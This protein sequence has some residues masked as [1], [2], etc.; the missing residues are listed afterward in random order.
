VGQA[1][2]NR[3]TAPA[4]PYRAPQTPGEP[5]RPIWRSRGAFIVVAALLVAIPIAVYARERWL[6][7]VMF[8]LSDAPF[9][10][11]WVACAALLGDLVLR[12]RDTGTPVHP[13]LRFATRVGLGLGIVSLCALGL[14]LAGILNR[15]TSALLLLIGPLAALPRF[16]A[17]AKTRPRI[18]IERW[19]GEPL[20]GS[21]LL[22][23]AAPVVGVMITGASIVPGLL[24]K[25]DDPHPYDV[26]EYHLQIPREWYELGRIVPLRHNVFSYFPNGVEVQYLM[27]MHLRGGA[28]AAMFQCQCFSLAWV[29]LA[30]ATV[31]GAIR[32]LGGSST[33]ASA[34][35]VVTIATPWMVM[36]G[37]VAYTESALAMYTALAAAWLLRAMVTGGRGRTA[38]MIVAGVMAGL[39]CGVKYT[40]VPMV[41]VA[42]GVIALV[43]AVAGRDRRA[44]LAPLLSFALA[45][46]AVASP[47]LIRNFVWTGNPVFPLAMSTLGRGHFD[48]VQVE[49]FRIAHSPTPRQRPLTARVAR[50]GDVILADWQYGYL[51]W[52]IA[53]VA[54]AL[55]WR[56]RE[57][58]AIAGYLVIVLVI[59]IGFTHLLG[60]FYVLTIPVAATSIG[61]VAWRHWPRLLA[62]VTPLFVLVS[63]TLTNAPLERGA[64]FARMGVEDFTYMI[65]QALAE[66]IK[67]T[68]DVWLVGDVQAFLYPVAASRLHYRTVFDLPGDA[69]DMYQAWLG[70][71]RDKAKGLIVVDPVEVERLSKTYY[72]VPGL[73]PDFDGPLDGPSIK[74]N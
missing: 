8:L 67:T 59:W 14:G 62:V 11:A 55:A 12:R 26:L 38:A 34:G 60:R 1:N 58:R 73:P 13:A 31:Y 25:P 41:A 3:S 52:P 71:P 28:W 21:W 47:W 36:L 18:P 70:I 69:T 22:V 65:P 4:I 7:V 35:A 46:A 66:Q 74:A 51:L 40:A 29:L 48:P 54:L 15:R 16:V 19:L 10:A 39:A 56:R 5:S 45:A 23:C 61:L 30:G 68:S 64:R 6:A 32:G 33:T 27:A 37:S 49:R 17:W 42:V 50:A 63:V 72:H 43:A 20:A 57:A 44:W 53:A 24:W 9:A 2:K